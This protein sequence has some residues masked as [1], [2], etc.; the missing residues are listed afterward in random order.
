MKSVLKRLIV[1]MLLSSVLGCDGQ[2]SKPGRAIESLSGPAVLRHHDP[3]RV[4]EGEALYG[5]YC[6]S[7]HG[8]KGEGH[9][10]WRV[11]GADNM[12][13]PPPL[14]GTGHAWHHS[15][16]W[17]S[18]MILNGSPAGQGKMPAW[19]GTLDEAQALAIIEWFQSQWSDRAYAAWHDMQNR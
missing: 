13:P 1:L 16:A 5:Q 17:L 10:Q 2:E 4:V 14:N 19:R 18:E 12:F 7:C 8:A 15:K 6:A 11:R 9:P 3:G